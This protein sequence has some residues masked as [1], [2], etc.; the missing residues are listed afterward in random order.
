MQSGQ[1]ARLQLCLKVVE[2]S[3]GIVELATAKPSLVGNDAVRASKA[4][5]Q[6]SQIHLPGP[7]K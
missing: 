2:W 1:A 4:L 3:L 6:M 5:G 7:K